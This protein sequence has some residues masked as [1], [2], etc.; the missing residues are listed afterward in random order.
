VLLQEVHNSLVNVKTPLTMRL[1]RYSCSLFGVLM[2][3]SRNAIRSETVGKHA[4]YK[5]IYFISFDLLIVSL[6]KSITV[7]IV[8]LM[9]CSSLLFFDLPLHHITPEL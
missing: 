7:C 2:V 5:Y 9:V 1:N 4:E 6:M 8:M 3:C